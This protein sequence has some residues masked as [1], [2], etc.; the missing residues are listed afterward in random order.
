[1]KSKFSV[2]SMPNR[3]A[4]VAVDKN[5]VYNALNIGF[6]VRSGKLPSTEAIRELFGNTRNQL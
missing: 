3:Y 4:S 1:M 2:T 6:D 5:P